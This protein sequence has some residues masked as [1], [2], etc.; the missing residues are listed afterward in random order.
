MAPTKTTDDYYAILE[1]SSSAKVNEITSSYRRLA[2]LLHPDRNKKPDAT[3]TFQILQSAYE[4]LS[5][6]IKRQVYDRD[7]PAINKAANAQKQ[8]TQNA[9]KAHANSCHRTPES[10]KPANDSDRARLIRCLY[11][12][13][14]QYFVQ[15]C[16]VKK[17]MMDLE[18]ELHRLAAQETEY[19]LQKRL[20][21]ERNSYLGVLLS[22]YEPSPEKAT[23]NI[24]RE[25]QKVERA[26]LIMRKRRALQQHTDN[27]YDIVQR[28]EDVKRSIKEEQRLLAAEINADLRREQE[29]ERKKQEASRKRPLEQATENLAVC[30]A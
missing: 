21:S 9:H 25:R 26:N 10:N 2:R 7:W 28:R 13:Y 1:L 16:A 4:T 20:K 12:H 19:K 22:A 17:Q 6:T 11:D 8:Y 24:A 5:D 30:R 29:R 27:V 14:E 3:K 18:L 23:E 15:I